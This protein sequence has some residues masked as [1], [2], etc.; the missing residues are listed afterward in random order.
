MESKGTKKL[1]TERLILRQFK[2]NDAEAMHQNWASDTEVYKYLM[3]PA[4]EDFEATKTQLKEWVDG[5][6][7]L[8]KYNWGVEWKETGELIGNILVVELQK[9]IDAVEVGYRMGKAWWGKGFMPEAL[10][11]VIE[12]F[13]DEVGVN[14]IAA[15]HDAENPKSGRVMEKAG[16]KREGVLRASARNNLG[17]RDAVWYS[18][19]K[20][21]YVRGK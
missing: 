12:Y 21:E 4:N 16:M 10:R 19:L 3:R 1:E 7:D 17:I 20:E 14:R 13:F 9:S 5:Y 6:T 8:D 11:A 15:R 18:I 2:L